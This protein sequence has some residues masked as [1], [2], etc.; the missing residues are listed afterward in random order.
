MS[1]EKNTSQ[2]KEFLL[3]SSKDFFLENIEYVHPV[4]ILDLIHNEENVEIQTT[5]L[6]RLP[7][8]MMAQL[9]DFEEDEDKYELLSRFSAR[10]QS[11]LLNDMSSDEIATLIG[12]LEDDD[13]KEV[14]TKMTKQDR[15]EINTLLSYKEDSAGSIMATEF[16]SIREN[17]TILKTFEYLQTVAKDAEMAYYLY[18]IDQENHLK[19]VVS[20][21]DLISSPF[22]TKI[23]ELTNPNVMS[24]HVDEDQEKVAGIF[25]R[26]D[27]VMLPVVDSDN[28]IVGVI[29]IDDI[30]DIIKEEATEDIHRMAGLNEEEKVDGSLIDSIKSRLPWLTINLGTAVLAAAV[31]AMFSDTIESVVALAAINPI[32]AGMGG[33]AGTQSLTIVVRGIALNELDHENALRIFFK[34]F[35]VGLFAGI[36]LGI[37]VGLGCYFVYGTPVLGFVAGFAMIANLVI[38]TVFGYLVPI[39]LN[40]L[41]VDPALAS[42]VFVT[43]ATD[44]LGFFIFLGLATICLP[45]LL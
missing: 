29:T 17:R 27:Y 34:E 31:V 10:K 36:A 35:G 6:N 28:R 12:A 3:N 1:Q 24:I 23:Q 7:N 42:S 41:K 22:N 44:V 40:K 33:N 4:D 30:V 45:Y 37:V 15:E 8:E 16:I 19:G 26:Y 5:I 14:L 39:I 38:A 11:N 43:T 32:I 21:R 20:T 25:E 2:L 18:V 13:K 9:L